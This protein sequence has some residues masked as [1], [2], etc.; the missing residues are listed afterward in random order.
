MTST[1]DLLAQGVAHYRAG[2]LQAA[3]R[4][5]AAVLQAD[6]R[7]ADAMHLLG[8][9]AHK[10][11]HPADALKL[12][13]D[14]LAVDKQMA[15]VWANRAL[16][17]RALGRD[18]DA[19]SS[20]RKALRLR[21]RFP[22]AHKQL[23]SLLMEAERFAEA[24]PALRKAIETQ[25][26][27]SLYADLGTVLLAVGRSTEGLEAWMNARSFDADTLLI[28]ASAAQQVARKLASAGDRAAAMRVYEAGLLS[29]DAPALK[30][31]LASLLML[32][33]EFEEAL[34]MAAE[35]ALA[36]DNDHAAW[37]GLVDAFGLCPVRV[38]AT[39]K[40]L[41]RAFTRSGVDH[42]LLER[43]ARL[44]IGAEPAIAAAL[45][46]GPTGPAIE[47][48]IHHPLMAPLLRQ[49]L[50]R[51]PAW[52]RLLCDVRR[53]LAQGSTG[54]ADQAA[55]QAIARQCFY[56]EYAWHSP[57]DQLEQIADADPTVR[58]M[59]IAP[60]IDPDL[61]QRAHAVDVLA[62]TD[63]AISVAVREMYEESPY[64]RLVGLH[65]KPPAPLDRVLQSLFP[66]FTHAPT[67]AQL[68]VLIAGC[69][70]GQQAITAANR[71]ANSE[72]LAVDL[73]RMSIAYAT[74][75]A[76]QLGVDNIRFAQA[77]ILGLGVLEQQFHLVEA[78]GVLHHMNDPMAGWRV[79]VDRT[80]QGGLMKIGLY[81]EAARKAVVAAR[82]LIA[83][84]GWP[85]TVA[86]IREARRQ[87][88]L[89]PD[90]HP[91]RPVLY[92]PDFVSISGTRDLIFHVCE[93]RF[94]IPQLADCFEQLGLQFVGFQHPRP[95]VAG[96]YADRWPDDAAQT[97]L[98][99]WHEVEQA[100]PE[101]FAGMYQFWCHKPAE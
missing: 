37:I 76:E 39:D 40:A 9:V 8:L 81:S 82:E 23:A 26:A 17:L 67:P 15:P 34:T 52:E 87:I 83:Q 89:L 79:L 27:A 11:G 16:P 41:E 14:A 75:K 70:T 80:A 86:G 57:S 33:G 36:S 42:Q 84:R 29:E 20:L 6:R 78:G 60:A 35:A 44:A 100:H 47:P 61:L 72:V 24:E 18:E 13:D 4:S 31:E 56:N 91:A 5:Y 59:Y 85:P 65:K 32:E 68:Q 62:M 95:E 2:E 19:E 63:D 28:S 51:H 74:Q 58:G 54:Q 73:S 66:H 101:A 3:A 1:S 77:D 7:N 92:S 98:N 88:A 25:P 69:G 38:P 43:A 48:F 49:T 21:P 99:R 55:I 45:E 30:A 97:D 53:R 64:P 96:W 90:D 10:L 22:Q 12:M 93:H 94:T 50:V 71:Y 46:G